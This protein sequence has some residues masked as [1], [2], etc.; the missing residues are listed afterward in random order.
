MEIKNRL[1]QEAI[2]DA[3]KGMYWKSIL[4]QHNKISLQS[5]LVEAY[6]LNNPSKLNQVTQWIYYNK[7]A[8]HWYSTWMTVD[9][10]YALLLADNPKDFVTGNTVRV[11]IDKEEA[12]LSN[13]VVG[14]VSKQFDQV[15]LQTDKAIQ[16]QNHND[17]V[18]YGSIVHQYFADLDQVKSSTNAL[19]VQKV[20]LVERKGKWVETKEA[21]LGEWVKVRITVINDDPIQY[22]HL[23]DSRPAGVEPVYSPS[24]YQW[25]KGYYYS[26][27]DASTNY[28]MDRLSKG[29]SIYEYEVKA[30][31]L[32]I[33]NSGITTI[34]CMYDPAINA[35]SANAIL[36]IIP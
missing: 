1:G 32:G 19:S 9:A 28:F 5:Y 22:V 10:V 24:G 11:L 18:I 17:R 23:K 20:Y 6:K 36:T 2:V 35:R 33:F 16:I 15:E 3:Q 31:N 25:R 8:N 12:D 30:N 34:G 4:N 26:S 14:E 7:Q 21:K 29:K 27:K 13:N